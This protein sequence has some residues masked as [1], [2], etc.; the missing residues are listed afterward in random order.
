MTNTKV[1]GS[2][3]TFYHNTF[4]HISSCSPVS[5]NKKNTVFLVRVLNY[6]LQLNFSFFCQCSLTVLFSLTPVLYVCIIF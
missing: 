5:T 6:F 1:D 2:L 3:D 4:V